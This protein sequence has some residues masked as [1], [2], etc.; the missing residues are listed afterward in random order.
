MTT[1]RP[2]RSQRVLRNLPLQARTQAVKVERI[3]TEWRIWISHDPTCNAGTFF[4]L[5]DN[6]TITRVTVEPD[7]SE[8]HFVV[9]E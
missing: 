1:P 3:G 4:A 8:R 2:T 6:G 5:A 9:N 7:G